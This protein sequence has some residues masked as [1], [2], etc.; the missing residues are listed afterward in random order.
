M[1][2]SN[3]LSPNADAG[4]SRGGRVAE[5]RTRRR[6]ARAYRSR[7]AGS[8]SFQSPVWSFSHAASVSIAAW[9]HTPSLS[10]TRRRRSR[11]RG[12]RRS[13]GAVART[14]T[15]RWLGGPP[16]RLRHARRKAVSSPREEHRAN[17]G[18]HRARGVTTA[19]REEVGFI[20][21]TKD[22]VHRVCTAA[23]PVAR[24]RASRGDWKASLR[25]PFDLVSSTVSGRSF[26][27]VDRARASARWLSL[28]LSL[29]ALRWRLR[30]GRR[31]GVR[32]RP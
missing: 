15:R 4:G 22:V 24:A 1:G 6:V 17:P 30:R 8:A 18:R 2:S 13:V 27:S 7:H 11:L 31:W 19:N 10:P 23:Y 20:R 26:A 3:A 28:R 29:Q 32:D 5:A 16:A 21:F 25:P 14:S 9:R 12:A